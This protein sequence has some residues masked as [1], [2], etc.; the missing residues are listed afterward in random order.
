MPQLGCRRGIGRIEFVALSLPAQLQCRRWQGIAFGA[1]DNT[2]GVALTVLPERTQQPEIF[3]IETAKI[4][5]DR[6]LAALRKAPAQTRQD[7]VPGRLPTSGLARRTGRDRPISQSPQRAWPPRRWQPP[8]GVIEKHRR[9]FTTGPHLTASEPQCS[10]HRLGDLEPGASAKT[11]AGAP[12]D[13]QAAR[14]A[15][16]GVIA[17]HQRCARTRARPPVDAA[18]IVARLIGPG[19][20]EVAAAAVARRH[21]LAGTTGTRSPQGAVRHMR[22][23]SRCQLCDLL[24]GQQGRI[25]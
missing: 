3:G 18:R 16:F 19:L 10:A 11:H 21:L 13:H 12:V 7:L 15:E 22:R 1:V 17:A 8:A 20:G 9:Q 2:D 5:H 24:P 23:G 6:Q 25:A 14:A 4:R